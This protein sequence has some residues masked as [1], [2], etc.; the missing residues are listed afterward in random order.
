MGHKAYVVLRN[1][2]LFFFIVTAIDGII[3]A[4]GTLAEKIIVAL[5]YG[6]LIMF[7][8]FLLGFFKITKNFW[9]QMLMAVIISFIFFFL[10]YNGAFGIGSIRGGVTDIG[11]A[12]M[13]LR[14]DAIGTL[15]VASLSS[16]LAS[17]GLDSL[18]RS[19]S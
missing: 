10:M 8:P 5:V 1:A 18:S 16:A 19:K 14:L 12:N 7:I 2:L 17:I 4:G 3:I 6:L 13:V 15:I 11:I 9:S